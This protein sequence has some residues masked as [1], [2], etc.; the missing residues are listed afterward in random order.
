MVEI[1]RES[2]NAQLS[3]AFASVEL[4]LCFICITNYTVRQNQL[5]HNQCV[6]DNEHIRKVKRCN[7]L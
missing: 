7:V 2:D 6:K 5:N 1:P 4:Q 3:N